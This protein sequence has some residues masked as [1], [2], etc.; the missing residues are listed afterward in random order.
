[1]LHSQFH[2]KFRFLI[3]S[4]FMIGSSQTVLSQ[5][6][7]GCPIFPANNVWNTRIDH[8]PVDPRSSDYVNSIGSDIGLHPD[9]GSGLWRGAPNGIPYTIVSDPIEFVS[10]SFDYSDESDMG[11]YPIPPDAAIEGG[12]DSTGDRH[13][14]IVDKNTC[15]LYELFAAYQNPDGSWRAGSGAI[16]DLRSNSLRPEGWTSADAAGLPILP[17]LA[18]FEE[19]ASGEIRHALRFTCEQTRQAY[20]WPARHYAS[21]SSD[22]TLPPMGQRFRLKS[23]FDTSGFSSQSK[24]IL[25]AL[26]EYGMILADNGGNWFISGCPDSGWDNDRL[27]N[28][29]RTVKGSDFEAVDI[30]SLIKNP[31]SAEIYPFTANTAVE[32]PKT[33]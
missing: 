13:I 5:E 30:S 6:L 18:R 28:E 24:V 4:L 3:L 29:L 11:P 31:D 21:R 27:V 33:Y 1:M 17:G 16:F 9:F 8:L 10:V 7:E 25:N 12:P 19:A 14:I 20:V 15:M 23:S 26:K 32:N 22:P 2:V